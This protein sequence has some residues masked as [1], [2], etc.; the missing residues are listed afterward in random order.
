VTT[1]KKRVTVY[2]PESLH[3]QLAEL[4]KKDKRSISVLI[5]IL[6]LEALEGRGVKTEA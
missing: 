5:E 2:I 6:V 1:N 4:A 3:D